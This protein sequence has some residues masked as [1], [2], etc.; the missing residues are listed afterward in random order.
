[1]P[2]NVMPAAP[3]QQ[4]SFVTGLAWTLIVFNALGVLVLLLQNLTLNVA[5]PELAAR[6]LP[7]QEGAL[8]L[9]RSLGFVFL[10]VS[11]FLTYAAYALLKRRNWARMTYI[12][13]F[14][15]AIVSHVLSA[16]ALLFGLDMVADQ[17]PS[18]MESVVRT[19]LIVSAVL[20]LVMAIVYGWLIKRLGSPGIKAEFAS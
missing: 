19:K 7:E 5:F 1:M 2:E 9:F 3:S 17:A 20:L 15:L 6:A 14:V 10:A 8:A 4:S 12:V 16:L 18:G 13:V 11:L